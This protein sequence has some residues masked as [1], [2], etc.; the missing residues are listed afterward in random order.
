MEN[1][2]C[3]ILDDASSGRRT[4]SCQKPWRGSPDLEGSYETGKRQS[5]LFFLG[6]NLN[7]DTELSLR[8]SVK[9]FRSRPCNISF[10]VH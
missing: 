8:A 4:V 6:P 9:R 1:T 2:K 5:F 10:S 7:S 3:V